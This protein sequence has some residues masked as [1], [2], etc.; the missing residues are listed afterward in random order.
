MYQNITKRPN[1]VELPQKGSHLCPSAT[2]DTTT[3][4]PPNNEND[5]TTDAARST[6]TIVYHEEAVSE[7]P[8]DFFT[9]VTSV[10]WAGI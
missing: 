6:Q 10:S 3:A 8:G 1:R 9:A 4:F 7:P 2:Q 5:S